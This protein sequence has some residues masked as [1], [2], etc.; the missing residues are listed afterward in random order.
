MQWYVAEF[1]EGKKIPKWQ[2][3][4]A[5]DDNGTIY[6]PAAI[7]GNEMSVFLAVTYDNI[8]VIC[9]SNHLYVPVTWLAREYPDTA[10]LCALIES[11]VK[12]TNQ[13]RE[14]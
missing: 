14:P 11:N 12:I 13:E 1:T 5:V 6:V 8:P 4:L 9:D 7:A 3:T 2:R 10:D